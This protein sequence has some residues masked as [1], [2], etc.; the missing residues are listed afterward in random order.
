M[1]YNYPHQGSITLAPRS[2]CG[3]DLRYYTAFLN[4][5]HSFPVSLFTRVGKTLKYTDSAYIVKKSDTNGKFPNNL[6][7]S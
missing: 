6:C 3:F 1:Q 4:I 5:T 7:F 2:S